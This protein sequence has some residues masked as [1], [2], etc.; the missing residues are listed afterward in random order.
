MKITTKMN[1][2]MKGMISINTSPLTNEFCKS[3]VETDAV[4]KS[5]YSTRMMKM[6]KS[7]DKAFT[8][9]AL[10]LSTGILKDIPKINAHTVRFNAHGELVNSAHM[11]NLMEIARN[12]P[13]TTFTLWTK[14]K[15]LV[16]KYCRDFPKPKNVIFIYSSPQLNQKSKKP[17]YFDKVFTVWTKEH[18]NKSFINCGDK[19]CIDCMTCYTLGDRKTFINEVLK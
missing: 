15:D 6:Y 16:W 9:N 19:K 8:D 18:K 3:M 7:A 11:Y 17:E 13:R 2:K 14:R 10:E 12:N 5:C 1:G 4:C